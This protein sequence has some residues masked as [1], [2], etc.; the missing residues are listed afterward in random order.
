MSGSFVSIVKTL[1]QLLAGMFVLLAAL[2]TYWE[3][4][5][6]GQH[7]RTRR[8]FRAKWVTVSSSEWLRMPQRAITWLLRCKDL[9]SAPRLYEAWERVGMRNVVS[10]TLPLVLG[11]ASWIIWGLWPAIALL[12]VAMPIALAR[13]S[14]SAHR[15]LYTKLT[16]SVFTLYMVSSL[17]ATVVLMTAVLLKMR[18]HH[19]AAA[20]L[21]LLPVYCAAASQAVTFGVF[22]LRLGYGVAAIILTRTPPR[23]DAYLPDFGWLLSFTLAASFAITFLALLI[24][25]I[26]D[27]SAWVPQTL[28]ML[29]SN[30]VF[31]AATVVTTI[32]ILRWAIASEGTARIPV[33]VG[34][35]LVLAALLA[36]CSLYFGL[37]FT[38]KALGL[39]EALH[40]L[41]GRSADGHK[42]QLGPYFWAM[43]TTFLPTL[44]YLSLILLAWIA[45]VLLLPV[46]WFFGKGQEHKNPL[47]LTAALCT[48]LAVAF[49]LLAACIGKAQKQVDVPSSKKTPSR[50]VKFVALPV[51]RGSRSDPLPSTRKE[52]ECSG[53]L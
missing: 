42:V 2:F 13:F 34:V 27:P 39:R 25:S 21:F 26:A 35:D 36:C 19:A 12:V 11:I 4:A 51:P 14:R 22:I 50:R 30:V 20:M 28:Q 44:L 47:K 33:A 17:S 18:I 49:G 43:H 1:F 38:D 3:V 52:V 46:K 8:W 41:L 32:A 23:R 5:Q 9:L 53:R 10:P 37:V 45:K 40:V 31:D 29:L 15:F 6:Q 16:V 48:L 24:G 7:E